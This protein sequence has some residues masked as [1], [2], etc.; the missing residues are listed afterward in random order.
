MW[1]AV[2][3][4]NIVLG[5]EVAAA[6]VIGTI[7]GGAFRLNGDTVVANG[8]LTEGAVIETGSGSASVRL[9]GGSR[10]SLSAGSGGRVYSD[11]FILDKGGTRLENGVGFHLQALGLT[12]R[13]D[14]G[15]SAGWIGLVGSTRVSVSALSGSFQVLNA[16]GVLV[17]NVAAGTALEFEP[18]AADV[19]THLTGV[20]AQQNG[21]FLLSDPVT[22]VRVE[23]T[24]ESLVA[25]VGKVVQVTGTRNAA[26]APVAGASQVIAARQVRAGT[27]AANGRAIHEN[28]IA[29]IDGVAVAAA[30]GGFVAGEAA[31]GNSPPGVPA[32]PPITPP[33]QPPGRPPGTPPGQPPGRPP[34]RPPVTPP[35]L[36]R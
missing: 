11:R 35:G 15:L 25:R 16:R 31:P 28:T 26:A 21:H 2:S 20:L 14:R 34:G 17:A 3:A 27:E 6:P 18:L 29:T 10:L 4:L 12:I 7:T 13:Q 1:V 33:G 8:T 30:K 24:G 9:A 23:V 32:G 36:S 5:A 22:G 19:P